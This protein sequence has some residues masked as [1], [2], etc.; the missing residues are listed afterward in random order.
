MFGFGK[1]TQR[2]AGRRQVGRALARLVPDQRPAGDPRRSPRRARPHR[3]ARRQA[4]RR[5]GSRRV[6]PVDAQC[7]A[8]RKSLTV[9]YIEHATRSSKI[10]HQLWSALFD[11][12]QAFLVAYYAFAREVFAPRAERQ[13]AAAAARAPRAARSSTWGS[14]P[15]SGC[16]ATSS[17]FPAKWAEL[18]GLFTLACSR[19]FE[20]AAAARAARAA[21]DDDRA[22]IPDRAAAAAHERRQHDRAPPRVGGRRARRMVRAAAP[23]ARA[24]VGRRRSTSTSARR[25]GLRRRTPAPLEGRVLFLDTRPLHSVLMQNVVMLEQKIKA[26]PLSDRTPKRS[27]QLGAA[28]QARVAG[29]SRIQAV[30]APRRAHG[31]GGHRRRDRRLRED[32][33]LPARGRARSPTSVGGARQELRRHDGARGVRPHAQRDRPPRR[34]RAPPLRAVRGARRPVG[35]QG[36]QPDRLP[37]ARADERRQRGHARHAGGDPRR[38]ARRRGRSASCAG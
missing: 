20:R 24:V 11:L 29:R 18:H 27:E 16:T 19:Q 36:R 13:V 17:G 14:T 28:H 9:Q 23:V 1:T 33:R 31:R 22:R 35:S 7:A 10:E 6:L 26:Q 8:L 30:R 34:A 38:T 12:T 32:L 21:A 2:P 15:R 37:P 3:R 25:D 5:S 4:H